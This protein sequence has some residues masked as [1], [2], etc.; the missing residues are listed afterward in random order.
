MTNAAIMSSE[1]EASSP[2]GRRTDGFTAEVA[3]T[4][5]REISLCA[6]RVLCGQESAPR[7]QGLRL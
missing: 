4:A 7:W 6:L 5:Q 2:A 3:E 1:C